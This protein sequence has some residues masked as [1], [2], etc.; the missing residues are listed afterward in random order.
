MSTNLSNGVHLLSELF[1]LPQCRFGQDA[2]PTLY[3]SPLLA[4]VLSLL[5]AARSHP[6]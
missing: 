3:P 5:L 1:L 4:Q 2:Q 6:V